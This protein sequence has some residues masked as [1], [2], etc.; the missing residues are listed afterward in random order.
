MSA[1]I[2]TVAD[3]VLRALNES[4]VLPVTA[5]RMHR[6]EFDLDALSQ[7][8]LSSGRVTARPQVAVV[9]RGARPTPLARGRKQREYSIEVGVVAQTAGDPA[10]TDALYDL[11][12]RIEA[13]FFPADTGQPRRLD[14]PSAA[15]V[16]T[17]VAYQP[18][19][20]A[21]QGFFVAVVTLTCRVCS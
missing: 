16:A 2:L 14:P 4:G 12:E 9:P 3:A 7:V 5:V 13:F 19:D 17:G 8:D 11:A 10:E 15:I 6:P 20:L 18:D 1:E 21:A